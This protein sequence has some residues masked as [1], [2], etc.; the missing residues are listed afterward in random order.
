MSTNDG[1]PAFPQKIPN[2]PHEPGELVIG[3]CPAPGISVRQYY[4][5]HAM[6]WMPWREG[7]AGA[8]VAAS[9]GVLAN[10]MIAEDKKFAEMEKQKPDD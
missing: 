6:A 4:K 10:A 1:G 7:I 5:A 2:A 3:L 8:Q 9:A